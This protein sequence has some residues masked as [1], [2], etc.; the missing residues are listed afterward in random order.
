VHAPLLSLPRI[1]G[2]TTQNV[3]TDV[4]YLRPDPEL[5]ERWQRRLASIQGFKIGISWKGNPQYRRDNQ[6]SV[7]LE[8]FAPLARVPGVALV[9]L[10]KVHGRE[11]LRAAPFPVAE[12]EGLDEQ[13]GPFMDTTAVMS[14]LDLVVSID[15][16]I[17]H[18]AGAL[19]VPCWVAL[20]VTPDWRWLMGRD[21]SPWYPS[22]R[23]FRA[24]RVADWGPVFDRMARE[25]ATRVA[26]K[27]ASRQSP[28]EKQKPEVGGRLPAGDCRL[29]EAVTVEIAP[30]ELID[31]I[32]ILQIKAQR[33]TDAD[34]LR[35]VRAELATL[36]ATRDRA[37]PAV[38]GLAA[39]TAELR[40]INESLWVIEDDIR[41][42]EREQ[43]FGPR[44]VE[45][46]R[47]V[48]H[49]NDR[50]AAVKRRINEL[51]GSTLRE[52]KQ[53]APYADERLKDEG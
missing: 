49:Q 28:V 43:D 8:Q 25:L 52:E 7:A 13:S 22:V 11:Q 17:S 27:P 42:C 24:A 23:L 5:A 21:D 34:K 32:T 37:L 6:R 44:F 41:R 45:L 36:S 33:I 50:R 46:A 1:F 9:S 40:A 20:P 15:S 18:L 26:A 19:A 38:P 3:P 48:Y 53:Y 4:P 2:T 35:N 14:S 31:K 39:L 47:S 16:A 29:T 10:Q 12:L 51:L 30:G